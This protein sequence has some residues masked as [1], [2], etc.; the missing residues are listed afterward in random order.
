MCSV[1]SPP[2]SLDNICNDL[3]AMS[4]HVVVMVVMGIIT[5]ILT[6]M[7]QIFLLSNDLVKDL[8]LPIDSVEILGSKLK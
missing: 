3:E 7:T 6:S 8:D 5:K 2:H 4:K 1:L